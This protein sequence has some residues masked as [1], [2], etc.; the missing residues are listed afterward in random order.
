MSRRAHI[1]CVVVVA[2]KPDSPSSKTG[3]K[4]CYD[5]LRAWGWFPTE[6]EAVDCIQHDAQ[7]LHENAYYQWALIERVPAGL[8]QNSEVRG[9]FKL[10]G[11]KKGYM[12]NGRLDEWW[13]ARFHLCKTPKW[14]KHICNW[15]LG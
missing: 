5:H 11:R 2:T 15:S 14:A 4:V 3:C 6:K 13:T 12:T 7:F 1:F 8:C 10:R 9:W